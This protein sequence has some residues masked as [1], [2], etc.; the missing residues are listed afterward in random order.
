MKV[1]CIGLAVMDI[2]GC[3]AVHNHYPG[4]AK[5]LYVDRDKRSCISSILYKTGMDHEQQTDR[6]LSIDLEQKN[7]ILADY[8]I[9]FPS[10]QDLSET[11]DFIASA[12]AGTDELQ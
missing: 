5:I 4:Q 7:K 12:I 9:P 3:M 8:I 2:S 1:L 11:V 10:G 6:I